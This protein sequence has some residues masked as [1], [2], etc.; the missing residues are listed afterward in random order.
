MLAALQCSAASQ[1]GSVGSR[2]HV[3][4]FSRS[5]TRLAASKLPE[6]GY[7][8][9]ADPS[10]EVLPVKSGLGGGDVSKRGGRWESDFIWNKDWAKQLDYQEA[11]RKQRE[12]EERKAKEGAKQEGKGFL[13]LTSKVDLNSMDVDLSEQLRVRKR[14]ST[15]ASTS[16]PAG[17]SAAPP[18]RRPPVKFASIPPTRVEQ[19]NWERSGKYSRKV[20]AA[21]PTNEVDQDALAAKVAAERARYDELKA[22][23]QAWAAGLTVACLAATFAFYGRDVAASY[24]V[25]ALGGLI[26]LR[27]LNRSVDGVGG[28]LGGAVGQPRL[29]I[30]V[31]LALGY[32]RYNTLVA[33][34]TGLTLELLPMLL[35]FFTYKGAVFA[36][37]SLELFGELASGT[38]GS[39]SGGEGGQGDQDGGS[40][41][42]GV[43]VTSVDRAFRRRM[44]N[45]M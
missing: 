25:G 16:A 18:R 10:A 21:T 15:Q 2:Q 44:L 7:F 20:V 43:D 29:L 11:Q 4:R 40:G 14:S 34:Q 26:Y 13:S 28:G 24:G 8:S 9:E 3:S 27:L 23:L 6:R 42:S 39:G 19:R 5:G 33:D 45:E 37:Q 36:K 31:I 35:G 30:P 22:E 38:S 41:G 17:Q 12:E 1:S 32:N